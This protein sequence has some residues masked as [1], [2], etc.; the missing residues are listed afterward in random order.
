MNKASKVTE[1]Q[2]LPLVLPGN[3]ASSVLYTKV[4]QG[5]KTCGNK[6]PVGSQGLPEPAAK[7]I[8]DWIKA[9]A[10]K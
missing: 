1:C 10:P 6:M 9:G 2:F 7:L 8:H 3:P 5:L 4:K